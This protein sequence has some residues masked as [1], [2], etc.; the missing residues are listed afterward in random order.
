MAVMLA[1][2]NTVATA[3]TTVILYFCSIHA[4]IEC[5]CLHWSKLD[6]CN[7]AIQTIPGIPFLEA[8]T[9]WD[10]IL[11][12]ASPKSG[13]STCL[14]PLRCHI[15]HFVGGRGSGYLFLTCISSQ[16]L[17]S[18]PGC[19]ALAAASQLRERSAIRTCAVGNWLW[20]L[21]ASQPVSLTQDG[22]ASTRELIQESAWVRTPQD[23]VS[24]LMVNVSSYSINYLVGGLE[25]RFQSKSIEKFTQ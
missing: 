17:L 22:G 21:K 24:V 18:L 10:L 6:Q 9:C 19:S 20:S 16:F 2:A 3:T 13:S 4:G 5:V 11:S 15:W 1:A 14:P 23:P 12:G 7:N 25:L 8:F